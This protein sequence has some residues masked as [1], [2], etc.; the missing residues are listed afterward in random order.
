MPTGHYRGAQ[1]AQQV[2]PG[3]LHLGVGSSGPALGGEMTQK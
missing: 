1:R 2:E 3:S